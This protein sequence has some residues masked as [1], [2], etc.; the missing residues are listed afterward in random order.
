MDEAQKDCVPS[1]SAQSGSLHTRFAAEDKP[2]RGRAPDTEKLGAVR[3]WG[4]G[5]GRGGQWAQRFFLE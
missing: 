4:R 1:G 5:E 2:R 3:R